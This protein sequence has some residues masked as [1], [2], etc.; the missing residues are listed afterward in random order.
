MARIQAG[1]TLVHQ[2][3]P[4]FVVS[5]NVTQGWE[6]V[7]NDTLKAFEAVDPSAN[8]IE[9]GF[10][11][12]DV[13]LFT[14]ATQQT[15]VVPFIPDTSQPLSEQKASFIITLDGAKQHIDAYTIN[16]D[17]PSVTTTITLQE[18]V[19]DANVE[20]VGLGVS[21]GSSIE[22]FGPV[23]IDADTPGTVNASYDLTWLAASKQSLIVS[24]D[25]VKQQTSSYSLTTNETATY[26]VLTLSELPR[27]DPGRGQIRI[28]VRVCG[29]CH[30]DLHTVEGELKLP[31]LPLVPGHQIVGVVDALGAPIDRLEIR[32][33]GSVVD[34]L[35]DPYCENDFVGAVLVAR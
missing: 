3:T 10:E 18:V 27:P 28:R 24:L 29:V 33:V 30:T 22:L 34:A 23:D 8:V 1:S 13:A 25:G 19:T 35:G 4:P 12:I 20:V 32:E 17:T 21:D 15:F 26:S 5:D 31:K 16:V 11:S 14:N 9:S 7:W 2:Y 6:L